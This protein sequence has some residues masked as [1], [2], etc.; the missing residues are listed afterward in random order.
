M[1][2]PR[3]GFRNY[4]MLGNL[5]GVTCVPE[6]L[7]ALLRLMHVLLSLFYMDC[8]LVYNCPK[9]SAPNVANLVLICYPVL[10]FNAFLWLHASFVQ[11]YEN[12]RTFHGTRCSCKHV[13]GRPPRQVEK[14]TSYLYREL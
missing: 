1:P 4:L 8:T 5:G 14:P 12:S 9:S 3:C 2:A 10:C 13:S 7:L 6:N 11:I